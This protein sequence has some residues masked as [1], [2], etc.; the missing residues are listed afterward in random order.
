MGSLALCLVLGGILSRERK[1][2]GY[3][4][5]YSKGASIGGIVLGKAAVYV[6]FIPLA[7]FPTVFASYLYAGILFPSDNFQAWVPLAASAAN[8][9]YFIYLACVVILMSAIA[10]SSLAATIMALAVTY[11]L[12][13]LAGLLKW[14]DAFPSYLALGSK[15]VAGLESN[16]FLISALSASASSVL[17]LLG[18]V[19]AMK[20]AEL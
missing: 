11:G 9:L 2:R 16:D 8:G 6:A 4:I 18:A 14:G 1:V 20:K 13:A 12:P 19:G 10:P 7:L 17:C 5:P 3:V 15:T